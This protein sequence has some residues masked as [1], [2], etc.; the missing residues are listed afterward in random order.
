MQLFALGSNVLL[1]WWGA[2]AGAANMA[3]AVNT[4]KIR[5]AR[6][7]VRGVSLHGVYSAE[8]ID[9]TSILCFFFFYYSFILHS[10]INP[11]FEGSFAVFLYDA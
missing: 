9:S 10:A 4:H 11:S 6:L 8:M 2:G 5:P 1:G 3:H 7:W